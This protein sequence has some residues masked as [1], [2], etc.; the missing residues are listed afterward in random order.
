[1]QQAT[2]VSWR[3]RGRWQERTFYAATF[4]INGHTTYRP[5]NVGPE[6]DNLHHKIFP[7][8]ALL[9]RFI[10]SRRIAF[11]YNQLGNIGSNFV[12]ETLAALKV[13]QMDS[14]TTFIVEFI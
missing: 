12:D 1:M 4:G 14:K 9:Q 6:R 11:W 13:V 10:K 8:K 7:V 5:I 2:A 3:R